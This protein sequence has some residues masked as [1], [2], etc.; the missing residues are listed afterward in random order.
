MS[1]IV[2][3]SK[4]SESL[5][6]AFDACERIV[7]ERAKNFW[8]GLRLTPEPKRSAMY[9]IY[10]WM[11]EADDIAD[12]PGHSVADRR[13]R[14]ERF[15]GDTDAALEGRVPSDRAVWVALAEV[16]PRYRLVA[17]DFHDMLD[18]QLA[19]LGD[20]PNPEVCP[21]EC[22]VRCATWDDLRLV[23]YRVASTVGLV[24]IRVWGYRDEA[25]AES[26][27]RCAID[28]GIA[29]QLTNI[30]RDVREDHANGRT[31]LPA[32]EFAR[33]GI[34]P[35]ALLSWRDEDRCLA[36]MEFQIRRAR[37]LYDG[38]ESLESMI[39]PDCVPTLWA[40][41]QIYQRLLQRI[42]R[43]PRRVTGDDR[44]RLPTWE[45]LW[46]GFKAKRMAGGWSTADMPAG[47]AAS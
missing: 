22:Q 30:L 19:D 14:L 39:S 11:R 26:A 41:T 29:F 37:A 17:K 4:H 9:A 44:V 20:G 16:A 31:Y 24:C 42:E 35:E 43:N 34:S 2:T 25:L 10:A 18:G 38:S 28:R 47:A 33:F 32:E 8:Y 40:L 45:K 21:E 1:D 27:I 15:R 12:E 5:D 13:A 6:A 7:R 36:F 23:C 46:V 3:A